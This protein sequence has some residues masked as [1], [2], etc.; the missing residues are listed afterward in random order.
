MIHKQGTLHSVY[1]AL[2]TIA[3]HT[4]YNIHWTLPGLWREMEKL[5]DQD[6]RYINEI[7][8]QEICLENSCLGS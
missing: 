3:K 1:I 7:S 6:V 5:L 2:E 4:A 8:E